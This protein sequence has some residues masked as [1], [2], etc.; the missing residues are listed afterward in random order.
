MNAALEFV[1]DS[2]D[3]EISLNRLIFNSVVDPF[4]EE[5]I[6]STE[7]TTDEQR[8]LQYFFKVQT[9]CDKLLKAIFEG[10]QQESIRLLHNKKSLAWKKKSLENLRKIL[11]AIIHN[12]IDYGKLTE[13]REKRFDE[14]V[15]KIGLQ[16]LSGVSDYFE[17]VK[18]FQETSTNKIDSKI[19][20]TEEDWVKEWSDAHENQLKPEMFSLGISLNQQEILF[21]NLIIL[22]GHVERLY[23]LFTHQFQRKFHFSIANILNYEEIKIVPDKI[24]LPDKKLNGQLFEILKNHVSPKSVNCLRD[25]W[26]GKDISE[27]IEFLGKKGELYSVFRFLYINNKITRKPKLIGELVASSFILPFSAEGP[28]L[29]RERVRDAVIK[30]SPPLP[31]LPEIQ[32]L[33]KKTSLSL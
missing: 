22:F 1:L 19:I 30:S 2:L 32:K 16:N 15:S 25:F 26:E 6:N 7:L 11:S 23:R 18:S 29:N 10:L 31:V 17:V 5:R 28:H 9:A 8:S 27:P 4:L 12:I 21:L 24:N 14:V 13:N 20:L 33:A 3:S